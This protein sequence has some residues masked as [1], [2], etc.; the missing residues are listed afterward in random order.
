MGP[1][2]R[3]LGSSTIGRIL[4]EFSSRRN[5]DRDGA[6]YCSGM[7]P[8]H[9]ACLTTKKR[10]DTKYALPTQGS[11]RTDQR[12]PVPFETKRMPGSVRPLG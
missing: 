8:R 11:I 6:R 9:G 10:P 2:Y 3:S 4:S 12:S 5:Q 7:R 1:V